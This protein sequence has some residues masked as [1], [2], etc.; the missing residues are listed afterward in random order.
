MGAAWWVGTHNNPVIKAGDE[1]DKQTQERAV[2]ALATWPQ[3]ELHVTD[4]VGAQRGDPALW[5]TLDW[6]ADQRKGDLK[7]LLSEHAGSEE[8]SAVLCTSQ[9]LTLHE[10]ALYQWHTPMGEIEEILWFFVP[11]VHQIAA[12]NRCHRDVGHPGHQQM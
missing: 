11:K 1:M 12:L 10:G 4:R 8:G 5:V 2:K 7:K 6:I 3:V 9:K